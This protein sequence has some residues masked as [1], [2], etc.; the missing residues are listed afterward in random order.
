MLYFF[1]SE[2]LIQMTEQEPILLSEK[3]REK[4]TWTMVKPHIFT[5]LLI[6]LASLIIVG[7]KFATP[8]ATPLVIFVLILLVPVLIIFKNSLPDSI[9]YPIRKLLVEDLEKPKPTEEERKE[10]PK[11]TLKKRQT[12]MLVAM[13]FTTVLI[14]IMLAKIYPE[15]QPTINYYTVIK[16]KTGLKI[17]AVL[18]LIC[19]QGTLVI[20]FQELIDTPVTIEAPE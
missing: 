6:L 1:Y 16:N 17:G 3:V 10:F 11:T 15:V 14:V 8:D 18:F 7:V 4:S 20:N 13:C 12:F 9:P 19:L 5:V 2:I